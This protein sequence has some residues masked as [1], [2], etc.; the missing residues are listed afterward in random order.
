VSYTR[1]FV[2]GVSPALG[3]LLFVLGQT[4]LADHMYVTLALM[5]A[6]VLA[7]GYFGTRMIG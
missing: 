5:L 2:C 7:Q 1:L 6:N 3:I 4:A